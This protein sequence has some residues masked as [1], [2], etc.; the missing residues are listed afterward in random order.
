MEAPPV[1][2]VGSTFAEIAC[3]GG[4][5]RGRIGPVC[6]HIRHGSGIYPMSGEGP[7]P[8]CIG[9]RADRK[10]ELAAHPAQSQHAVEKSI[11][12]ICKG[13]SCAIPI[14]IG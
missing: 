1:Q 10:Q 4:V 7:L 8:S 6:Q 3:L 11:M 2:E 5:V 12:V 13:R 14:V 9:L